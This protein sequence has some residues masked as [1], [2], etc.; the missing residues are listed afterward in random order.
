RVLGDD[1]ARQEVE[2]ILDRSK[3]SVRELLDTNRHLVEALRDQLL[4]H[5]ELVGDEITGVL[6]EA[7]AA[8]LVGTV[9]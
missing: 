9:E 7:R 3:E 4:I 6:D 5:D 1:Q 8:H 2:K